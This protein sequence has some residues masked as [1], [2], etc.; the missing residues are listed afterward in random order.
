MYTYQYNNVNVDEDE[1]CDA[2][3]SDSGNVFISL[4]EKL[5]DAIFLAMLY[6]LILEV[7][8]YHCKM[9]VSVLGKSEYRPTWKSPRVP[10]VTSPILFSLINEKVMQNRTFL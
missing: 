10:K 1:N 5:S 7:F 3:D 4:R 2:I 8:T 6:I 9:Q